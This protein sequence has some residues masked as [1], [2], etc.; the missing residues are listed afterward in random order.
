[1]NIDDLTLGQ[2]RELQRLLPCTSPA[3]EEHAYPVG[4]MVIIRTV[5][6]HYIGRLVKVTPGELVLEDCCW[7]ASSGRWAEALKTGK[8][9]E[10]EPYPEGHTPLITRGSVVDCDVWDH[11]PILKVIE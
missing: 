10:A 9:L 2:I 5:T 8:V 7:L 3:P 1:M 4:K 11:G 6:Y